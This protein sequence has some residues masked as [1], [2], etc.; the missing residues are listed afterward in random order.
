MRHGGVRRGRGWEAA[1]CIAAL[2]LVAASDA[3]AATLAQ[4]AIGPLHGS[5][6]FLLAAPRALA[7]LATR[8]GPAGRGALQCPSG[9]TM[10]VLCTHDVAGG[11]PVYDVLA[12][13][14]AVTT[15]EQ[16][17]RMTGSV[18]FEGRTPGE[19]FG[20][21]PATFEINVNV[22]KFEILGPNSTLMMEMQDVTGPVTIGNAPAPCPLGRIDAVLAGEAMLELPRAEHH[23]LHGV[24]IR[25]N[26]LRLGTE[27]T[28]LG[29]TCTLT[30]F[31]VTT[32]GGMGLRTNKN[33]FAVVYDGLGLAAQLGRGSTTVF[34]SGGLLSDCLGEPVRFAT[35]EAARLPEGDLCFRAGEIDL[36][37]GAEGD[38]VRY[39]ATGNVD[40][41]L[42]RDGT[43]DQR[44]PSCADPALYVCPAL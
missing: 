27:I 19:C 20:A 18:R 6:A 32:S 11:P 14:C 5:V 21:G 33:V 40:I 43:V 25:F 2:V 28:Q 41:D 3:G 16:S 15:T 7:L 26:D 35:E 8:L 38:H 9:G 1:A 13:D 44:F 39:G 31:N 42:G 4:K 36:V 34:L 29:E 12:S 17:L 22:M 24:G 10:R 37:H 23:P 30:R